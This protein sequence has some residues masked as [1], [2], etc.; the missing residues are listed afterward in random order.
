MPSFISSI[1]AVVTSGT[2][3]RR[4]LDEPPILIASSKP[5]DEANRLLVFILLSYGACGVSGLCSWL[6]ESNRFAV[7]RRFIRF[8]ADSGYF[9]EAS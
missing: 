5:T 3:L 8:L 1:P 9:G 6:M 2:L 7:F 4:V